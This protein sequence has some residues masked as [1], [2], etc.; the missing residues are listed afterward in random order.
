M[1]GEFFMVFPIWVQ[2]IVFVS[3]SVLFF[4]VIYDMVND[5]VNDHSL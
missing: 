3:T 4:V 1:C 2:D 5:I